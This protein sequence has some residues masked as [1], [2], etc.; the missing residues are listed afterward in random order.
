MVEQAWPLSGTLSVRARTLRERFGGRAS[1]LACRPH[2]IAGESGA[3]PERSRKI[4]GTT[5]NHHRLIP[6]KGVSFRDAGQYGRKRNSGSLRGFPIR[7]AVSHVQAAL[8]VA[9]E[10]CRRTQKPRGVRL[11]RLHVLASHDDLE[12]TGQIVALQHRLDAPAELR[13][14]D[15]QREAVPR[16]RIQKRRHDTV[17]GAAIIKLLESLQDRLDTAFVFI[18]HDLSTVASFANRIVVLYAGRVAEQG[19]PSASS[20][21]RTTRTRGCC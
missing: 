3:Q 20:P 18:S 9:G 1:R 2:S 19:P 17:V 7:H 10:L 8:H 13:R 12:A 11:Q 15:A 6:R 5:Q 16:Q 21:R 14:H 4:A